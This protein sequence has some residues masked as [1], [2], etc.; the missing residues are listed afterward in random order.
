VLWLQSVRPQKVVS[1]LAVQGNGVRRSEAA[2][3]L[4]V[5]W[6]ALQ[7]P[8]GFRRHNDRHVI[9]CCTRMLGEKT[10]IHSMTHY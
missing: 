7:P 4:R 2:S 8:T 5:D 6:S 1:R 10:Y 9:R 3:L